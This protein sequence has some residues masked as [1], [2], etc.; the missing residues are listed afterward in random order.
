MGVIVDHLYESCPIRARSRRE[1]ERCGWWRKLG[2]RVDVDGG[3][4]CGWCVRVW[5]ARNPLPAHVVEGGS[6][7]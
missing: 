7:A 2:A 6:T 5:K 3:E 4:L 1:L